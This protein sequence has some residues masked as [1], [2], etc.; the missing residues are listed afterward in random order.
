MNVIRLGLSSP[1]HFSVADSR[2]AFINSQFD[3]T[4]AQGG[5]DEDTCHP[6]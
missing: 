2:R 6:L 4:G 1:L 5:P 3:I